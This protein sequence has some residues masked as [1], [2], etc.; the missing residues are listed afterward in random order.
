MTSDNKERLA[1]EGFDYATIQ[2]NFHSL[3]QATYYKLER[4]WPSRYSTANSAR[5]LFMMMMALASNTYG[6]IIF[7]CS[8]KKRD[9]RHKPEMVISVPPLNRRLFEI[10]QTVIFISNDVPGYSTKFW[11]S[12]WYELKKMFDIYK[13]EYGNDP[14][15][16]DFLQ[17]MAEE[18][19][20]GKIYNKLTQDEINNPKRIGNWPTPGRMA[21]QLEKDNPS[22][23]SLAFMKYLNDMYY[24][25]LSS[26]SHLDAHGLTDLAPFITQGLVRS[27]LGDR[28]DRYIEEGFQR[29]SL[30]QVYLAISTIL[31]LMSEFVAHFSFDLRDRICDVWTKVK[32]YSDLADDFY[33][34]RYK[35]LLCP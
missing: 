21:T 34:R 9:Y 13:R 32:P 26:Y 1:R 29:L 19:E 11:K 6:T 2:E 17:T 5:E 7:I 20:K 22:S 4:E 18:L 27:V 16:Q 3:M 15:W 8:D 31:A 28:A 23:P 14:K 12:G 33:Q 30:K 10:L 25:E 35:N 24:K